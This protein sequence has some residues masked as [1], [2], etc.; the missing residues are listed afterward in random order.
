MYWLGCFFCFWLWIGFVSCIDLALAIKFKDQLH[1][2][3]ENPVAKWILHADDYEM[4]RFA[5]IKMFGTILVL[6]AL[7][8]IYRYSLKYAMTL[9]VSLALFQLGLLIYLFFF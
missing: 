7:I 2:S 9:A 1:V 4:S 5:A 3:E 8:K 6:G